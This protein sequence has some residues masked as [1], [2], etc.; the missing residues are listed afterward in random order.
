[1]L[2]PEED[3]GYLFSNAFVGTTTAS[4]KRYPA[5]DGQKAKHLNFLQQATKKPPGECQEA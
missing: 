1:M 5:P 2:A 3:K 4:E